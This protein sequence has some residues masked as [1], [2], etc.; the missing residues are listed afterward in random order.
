M[1][2]AI[3]VLALAA[4]SGSAFAQYA[5]KRPVS[6]GPR[7]VGV[8]ELAENGRAHL[9]PVAIMIDGKFYDAAAYKANP[10]P[11]AL[12]Y[13]TVYEGVK[14]GVSQGLFTVAGAALEKDKGLW[15][16]DGKW[17]T[18]AD[19]EAEKSQAKAALA[20]KNQKAP[21][22]VSGPPKL[23]RAPSSSG[24][25]SKPETGETAPQPPSPPS[26]AQNPGGAAPNS[27]AS[28]SPDT[29]AGGNS[30][31]PDSR[32]KSSASLDAPDR[33]IL[34]REAPSVGTHGQTKA[35]QPSEPLK[36]PVQLLP[37]ISDAAGPEPRPYTYSLKPEEE[38]KF[39]T[40]MLA[41]TAEEV[42]QRAAH[43]TGEPETSR[44][45]PGA[46]AA[47]AAAAVPELQNVEM[48]VFDLTNSN[49]PV[50]VMTA[51][52]TIPNAKRNFQYSTALV[53]REDIYGELHKVFA[54]T[55]D[56]EHLDALAKYEFVDAVDADGDGRGELLFRTTSDAGSAFS[57]YVVI[58]DR[59]W[60]LF[61]GKPGA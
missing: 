43:L 42:K 4:A 29:H 52:A 40:K 28:T 14:S 56:N 11:M 51:S 31:A 58:G 33:P 21:E 17:R 46:H 23:R 1:P 9:V 25:N 38:Q 8:L 22:E 10:V 59:L 60:P 48:R 37:A 49:E 36:G 32:G 19:I 13:E 54:Q 15:V 39:K 24:D 53:A 55:T 35:D 47:R 2:G 5:K 12:Q 41:M 20:R 45:A 7:A 27:P 26:G 61:E 50:L 16:A 34:R 6:K 3:L 30:Q 44:S 57:I 18:H